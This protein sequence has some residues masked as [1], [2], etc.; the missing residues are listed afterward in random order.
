MLEKGVPANQITVV[1][2][3]LPGDESIN[4]TSPYA[5]GN[6]SCI[7]GDDPGTLFFDKYTYTNL[8]RLQ[9]ALG[10]ATVCG[11]DRCQSTEYFDDLPS[12]AKINSLSS[13][14]QD[15]RQLTLEELAKKLGTVFGITFLSWSF[16][17]PKFLFRF[18]TYLTGKGVTFVKRKLSHISQAYLGPSTKYVFNCTGIGAHKLGGVNDLS[19]YP[20][21]GQVV[22]IKAPHVNENIMRWGGDYATYI[23]KR[24]FSHDQLILG[25]YMQKDNW[26]ADTFYHETQDILRRTTEL[27]PEILAK[28]PGGNKVEDLEILRTVSG[29]R[30]SRH[31]GVRIE[32]VQVEPG[33]FLI[34][35]YGAS[36]YGYQAGLGMGYEAVSLALDTLKL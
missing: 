5:G 30:P 21:R 32:K 13:Y 3:H 25:G 17:C 4:Y 34:H 9:K 20:T 35:N 1:A 26:T 28:N 2:E 29:L 14:L 15:Y 19:V 18:Y 31:G 23:I 6:F 24:P 7:S 12:E 8:E 22:V 27:L 11:V 33:K 10:G 36:G 16:N